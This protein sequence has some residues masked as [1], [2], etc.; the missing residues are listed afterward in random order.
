MKRWNLG[1]KGLEKIGKNWKKLEKV[2]CGALSG[3]GCD[4]SPP[5]SLQ[6]LQASST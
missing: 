5:I 3:K 2:G 6:I 4:Q 1:G